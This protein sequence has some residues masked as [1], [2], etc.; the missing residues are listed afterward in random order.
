MVPPA[1]AAV[2]SGRAWLVVLSACAAS[3]VVFGVVYSFGVFLQ[4][5]AV[6][7][8]ANPAEASG[9]L[10]ITSVVYYVL[11]AFAGRAADRLGA[12]I[13]VTAGALILGLGLCLTALVD[14]I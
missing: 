1:A 12:R 7:F 14:R 11:G 4:P 13:V 10:S 6:E 5:V 8:H 3:F 9:F 2:D